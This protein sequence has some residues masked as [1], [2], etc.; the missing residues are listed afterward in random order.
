[1]T[2]A[3]RKS[4]DRLAQL[5][6]TNQHTLFEMRPKSLV[7]DLADLEPLI[8]SFIDRP[9]PRGTVIEKV[10]RSGLNYSETEIRR[11]ITTLLEAGKISSASSRTKINDRENIFPADDTGA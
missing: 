4:Q 8:L 7:P 11:V 3:M 5:A 6:E 2:N 9:L 1:M 10:M